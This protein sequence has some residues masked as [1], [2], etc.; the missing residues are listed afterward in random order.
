M[1]GKQPRRVLLRFRE[2]DRDLF[3]AVKDGRKKV[4]TRAATSRY[5]GL[6]AGDIAVLVCG[7]DKFEKSV[8]RVETFRTV[9]DML[10]HYKIKDINPFVKSGDELVSMYNSFTGYREKISNYGLI[11]IEL[12]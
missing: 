1:S 3:E 4:E 7:K 5:S 10:Q 11:A 2:V 6:G 9:K 8:R 12:E